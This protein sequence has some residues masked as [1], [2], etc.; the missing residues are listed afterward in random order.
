MIRS[1]DH[2]IVEALEELF[3][4]VLFE[5]CQSGVSETK[6]RLSYTHLGVFGVYCGCSVPKAIQFSVQDVMADLNDA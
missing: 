6:I 2:G 5:P 1:T 4:I 3:P